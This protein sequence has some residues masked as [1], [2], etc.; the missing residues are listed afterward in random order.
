MKFTYSSHACHRDRIFIGPWRAI[1]AILYVILY[2]IFFGIV[3]KLLHLEA[4][5]AMPGSQEWKPP[6]R[7]RHDGFKVSVENLNP[8]SCKKLLGPGR[9]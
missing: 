5:D 1:L 8:S 6:T 3:P 4:H 2:C 7:I 9:A